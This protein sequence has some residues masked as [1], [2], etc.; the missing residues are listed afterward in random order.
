MP[1]AGVPGAAAAPLPGAGVVATPAARLSEQVAATVLATPGIIRLEPTLRSALRRLAGGAAERVVGAGAAERAA[2]DQ[3]VGVRLVASLVDV[4]V[5][6]VTS[7]TVPARVTAELVQ[8][9][10]VALLADA[11]LQPGAV[12]VTVLSVERDRAGAASL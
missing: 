9:R 12:T 5:D 3:L 1:K 4:T 10:I 11:G 8:Q 6:V 2:T 7:S